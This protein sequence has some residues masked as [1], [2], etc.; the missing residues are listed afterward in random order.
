ML[1]QYTLFVGLYVSD[2]I[3][4]HYYIHQ[5]GEFTLPSLGLRHHRPIVPFVGGIYDVTRLP[6]V[7]AMREHSRF[8]LLA[9]PASNEYP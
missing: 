5:V 7:L 9:V 3:T 6:E 1:M 2:R 8:V 4:S